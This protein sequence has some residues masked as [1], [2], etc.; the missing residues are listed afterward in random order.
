MQG[1][2]GTTFRKSYKRRCAETARIAMEI[3][4]LVSLDVLFLILLTFIAVLDRKVER[5]R[6]VYDRFFARTNRRLEALTGRD[7]AFGH[8]TEDGNEAQTDQQNS[9][10]E[11]LKALLAEKRFTEGIASILS[12]GLDVPKGGKEEKK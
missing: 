2:S 11:Q 10:E 5:M 4:I 6:C 8:A 9:S 1:L 3:I 12:Y 7:E